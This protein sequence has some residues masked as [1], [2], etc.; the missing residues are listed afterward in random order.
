MKLVNSDG[1]LGRI[2]QMVSWS[3]YAEPKSEDFRCLRD[4]IGL[5]SLSALPMVIASR[6]GK[7]WV[8]VHHAAKG[9]YYAA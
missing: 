6:Q 9:Y 4:R 2:H 8:G 3:P 5:S 1:K 7:C